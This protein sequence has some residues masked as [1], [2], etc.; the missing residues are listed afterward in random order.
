MPEH[1]QGRGDIS[2]ALARL[3]HETPLQQGAHNRRHV[4]RERRPVGLETHHR[5]EHVGHILAVEGALAGE[6]LE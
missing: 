1:K 3:F 4:G 6:H 5:A 2:D